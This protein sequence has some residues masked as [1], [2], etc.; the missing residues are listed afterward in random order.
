MP[1][2]GASLAT[3]GAVLVTLIVAMRNEEANI[4]RC[5]GSIRAQAYPQD[6]LEVFVID[7]ASTDR[8]REVAAGLIAGLPGWHLVDNPRRIQAAAWNLGIAQASG[9]VIGILSGHSELHA[10]Y[11]ANA[12]ETLQRTRAT[13]VGGPVRALGG[14]RIGAA[15]ALAT[16]S[17]FGVGGATFR[18]LE[19]EASVDTVFMGLCMAGDF[20]RFQFDEELVRDQDDELSYRI[21]DA[22]G[23]IICNPRIRSSYRSRSTYRSLWR[24]YFDYGFWKVRVMQKHPRQARPRQI[25]P[26]VFVCTSAICLLLAPGAS[27]ARRGSLLVLGSYGLANLAASFITV[28]GN[29]V[30]LL[31]YVSV[32]YAV[33]H[34]AYGAGFAG[35]M[36]RFRDRWPSGALAAVVRSLIRHART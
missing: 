6:R 34:V 22:G 8:S 24:Q 14:G 13:M 5:I 4:A 16:S 27:L 11:V 10:D 17:P 28:R 29:A 2:A 9:E 30:R 35:G 33:I 1:D 23:T 19:R 15:V 32:S 7:G 18:Y 26:A 20:R 12:V 21:L 31:P 25:I 3:D 36:V